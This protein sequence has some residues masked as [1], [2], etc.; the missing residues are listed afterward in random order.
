MVTKSIT[1]LIDE[2]I[3]PVTVLIVGKMAGLF[4]VIYFLHLDFTVVPA[5]FLKI[6]PTVYFVNPTSYIIAENYSNLAMFIL[7]SVGTIFVITRAHFL[8]TSHISPVLQAKLARLNLDLF[9]ASSYRLYH[10]AAIW[11][12]FL[13]LTT[14]FL[15]L[16]TIFNITYPQIS[17]VAFIVA[18][19]LS[20]FLALDIE[21]EVEIQ[22]SQA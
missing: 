18:A 17:V 9:I 15:M 12:T 7:A 11:I 13:W 21:K 5:S 14:A 4:A 2:A 3:L 20:W 16:S 10:Q 1:R 19:N 8:H 6:L 22:R